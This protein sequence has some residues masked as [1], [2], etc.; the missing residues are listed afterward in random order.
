MIVKSN[1]VNI[2]FDDNACNISINEILD[3][4]ISDK[5]LVG[6]INEQDL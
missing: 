4:T 2:N 6:P 1:S 3:K 5:I